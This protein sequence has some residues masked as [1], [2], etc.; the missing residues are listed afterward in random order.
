MGTPS[1]KRDQLAAFH[2]TISQ[3][4]NARLASCSVLFIGLISFVVGVGLIIF[5]RPPAAP[6][7][8][9]LDVARIINAMIGN[10]YFNG[11]RCHRGG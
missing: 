9:A 7:F 11:K 4:L 3:Q 10:P 2:R 6:R 5:F 8:I 1:L